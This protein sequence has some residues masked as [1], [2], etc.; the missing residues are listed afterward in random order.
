MKTS[1]SSI[2]KQTQR[3]FTLV[4][5]AIVLVI[6]GLLIGGILR[7]QELIN[8]ARTRSVIAQQ[9]SIQTAYYGF[10]DRYKALPGDLT[11]A[12]AALV[13]ASTS[14]ATG[15]QGNGVVPPLESPEFFNNIAQAGMISC[16][17]CM[18]QNGTLATV[19]T[20]A[21]ILTTTNSPANTFGSPVWFTLQP[22]AQGGIAASSLFISTTAE[23]AT[24]PMV[25]TGLGISSAMLA[26]VDRKVDDGDPTRGIFRFSD[27]N[28]TVTPAAAVGIANCLNEG[29]AAVGGVTLAAN[30]AGTTPW[31]VAPPGGN[32]QGASL[33]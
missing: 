26:E 30:M 29:G 8:T 15:I 28:F 19:G 20:T 5:I 3:G 31:M 4:E 14:Q 23:F 18:T 24:K 32:C 33:M 17:Q 12:Q 11:A 7:G 1:L 2:K 27:I 22:A 6:I 9:S 25:V 21:T 10:L 13:N 16:S